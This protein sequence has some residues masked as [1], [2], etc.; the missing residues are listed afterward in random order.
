VQFY[1]VAGGQST[2][3]YDGEYSPYPQD[4]G[5]LL[6]DPAGPVDVGVRVV[7]G[8]CAGDIMFAS[9]NVVSARFGK[10]LQDCNATGFSAHP[11]EVVLAHRGN[12]RCRGY[13]VIKVLG[14]ALLDAERSGARYLESGALSGWDSLH[15]AEATWDGSD[16]F[17]VGTREDRYGTRLYVVERVAEALRRAKLRN[18]V[19]TRND[20]LAM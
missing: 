17:A 1:A 16:E 20:K 5:P 19:L 13:F 6:L 11:I 14:R 4:C 12:E 9:C 3:Y 8:H 15:I 2:W 18:V 7:R 10:A